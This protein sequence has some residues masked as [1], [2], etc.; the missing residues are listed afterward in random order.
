[1]NFRKTPLKGVC[2]PCKNK[3]GCP[4]ENFI[5][6]CF[7]Q[8]QK[9]P[10]KPNNQQDAGKERARSPLLP[11]SDPTRPPDS[12]GL[13]Q[14]H[15]IY[16]AELTLTW[17]TGHLPARHQRPLAKLWVDT[18]QMGFLVR[19]AV[20]FHETHGQKKGCLRSVLVFRWCRGHR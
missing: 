9:R 1:M 2:S 8:R 16:T 15:L 11:P 12:P 6:I 19:R 14:T 7:Q 17:R 4:E 20:F 3:G 5:G 18:K 13:V 10:P